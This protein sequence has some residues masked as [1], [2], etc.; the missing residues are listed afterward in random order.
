VSITSRAEDPNIVILRGAFE[1]EL[2]HIVTNEVVFQ[3]LTFDG[4]AKT[5]GLRVV[6]AV[7]P[8][9]CTLTGLRNPVV[10]TFTRHTGRPAVTV[11]EAS[12]VLFRHCTVVDNVVTHPGT[13]LWYPDGSAFS[14]EGVELQ[15][16]IVAQ[17]PTS[18]D[19]EAT[20]M[21]GTWLDG[22]GNVI[23]GN[24]RL[25]VLQNHGGAT[26]TLLP[27]PGSPAID[28]GELSAIVIDA[29]GLSRLAGE[30]PD[31]GATEVG[32]TAP[33]DSDIDG[34]PDSWEQFHS[35]DPSESV[36]AASDTDLDGQSAPL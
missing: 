35:L 14:A 13:S 18:L 7:T 27:L 2:F 4:S 8:R 16:C 9:D 3:G 26:M 23:G 33:R 34:L 28:A 20:G 15:N 11:T 19:P 17:N 6:G 1:G 31:A 5:D 21:P 10:Q 32:A 22:G 29:R 25:S 36:D 24:P 30:A 12:S